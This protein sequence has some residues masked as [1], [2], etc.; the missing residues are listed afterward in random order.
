MP[1]K[2]SRRRRNEL[3]LAK[4]AP[5]KPSIMSSS[6]NSGSGG[7]G[8]WSVPLETARRVFGRAPA[9]EGGKQ[10]V[11]AFHCDSATARPTAAS[12]ALH[13]TKAALAAALA[14]APL[15]KPHAS[16]AWQR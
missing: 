12:N 15:S 10:T 2:A 3:T 5:T 6:D 4:A 11:G 13:S 7:S 9:G 16:D 1:Q 8:A 14:A